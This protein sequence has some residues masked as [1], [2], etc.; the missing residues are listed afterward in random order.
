[1]TKGGKNYNRNNVKSI[2]ILIKPNRKNK[3]IY[4]VY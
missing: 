2:R 3:R 1:M 4:N